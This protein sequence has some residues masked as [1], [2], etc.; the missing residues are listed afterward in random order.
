MI[1]QVMSVKNKEYWEKRSVGL[2]K[3]QLEKCAKYYNNLEKNFTLAMK[4]I[5]R[6]IYNWY[7]RFAENNEI[8]Y[9][10]AKQLL[11]SRE[12]KEFRWTV[13]EY[14]KYGKENAVN[15]LW[16]K[17]LENASA[18]VH[19]KR[20]EALKLQLQ[21]HIEVLYGNEIDGLE[22]I[23]K[24]IY[25][26]SYYNN[27]FNLGKTIGISNSFSALNMNKIEK[28][29]R[30]PWT[31]DGTN[32]S[33]RVWGKHRPELINFL[34]RELTQSIIRGENPK[35][36]I[37]KLAKKFNTSKSQA[38]NVL[39]TESAFFASESTKD[40]FNSLDVEEFQII[41]TLDLRTSE[42]C[43]DMDNKVFN[44]EDY[45]IGSTAPPFHPRCRTT[46]APY[47][48]DDI[49]QRIARDKDGKRHYV[50][51]NMSYIEWYGK[52]IE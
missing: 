43:Q 33:K 46:T 37:N 6:D 18:R 1:V 11:N 3:N 21:Q 45:I 14:I 52:Y 44:M 9:V 40:C 15:E 26:D 5:E 16:I 7:M 42:I 47:F 20:L 29:L 4:N 23:M 49:G 34:E 41:A 12:L 17:Q 39:F 50:P 8:T 31:P 30:Q 28:V 48:D 24:D 32:F 13:K 2:K 35:V 25:K 27:V 19:I 10:E 36:L 51:N 38:A 22:N